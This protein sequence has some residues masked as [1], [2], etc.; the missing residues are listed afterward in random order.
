MQIRSWHKWSLK[1]QS[2]LVF[3]I[4]HSITLAYLFSHIY[5][6]Q[7]AAVERLSKSGWIFSHLPSSQATAT[8]RILARY[9]PEQYVQ[10]V[11]AAKLPA[12]FRIGKIKESEGDLVKIKNLQLLA[13]VGG[14]V[15]L[16]DIETVGRIELIGELC[17]KYC[18]F[19]CND[20]QLGA[21]ISKLQKAQKVCL[22]KKGSNSDVVAGLAKMRELRSVELGLLSPFDIRALTDLPR[23][24]RL[25][26]GPLSF[27]EIVEAVD[28]LG[29]VVVA[30]TLR[31]RKEMAGRDYQGSILKL[32]RPDF[33]DLVIGY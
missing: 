29:N 25:T 28:G 4:V 12:N 22:I 32:V 19:T 16:D 31:E 21:A 30:T 1:I 13:L 6:S 10:P 2:L 14:K 26:V 24:E 15:S 18:E 3:V 11:V 8:Q 23:L 7:A 33:P 20:L 27:T 5:F 9:F 17:I